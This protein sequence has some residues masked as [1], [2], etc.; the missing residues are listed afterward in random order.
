[1][2]IVVHSFGRELHGGHA[3]SDG[4]AGPALRGAAARARLPRRVR[5][6]RLR[7]ACRQAV[8]AHH[9]VRSATVGRKG[10]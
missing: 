2:I 4:A 3:A 1:M 6:A 8:S 7:R 5:H 9:G 10:E